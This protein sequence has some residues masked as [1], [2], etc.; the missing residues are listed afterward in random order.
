MTQNHIKVGW[1]AESKQPEGGIK[2]RSSSIII[3]LE[4]QFL[5]FSGEGTGTAPVK[6]SQE[7]NE[8]I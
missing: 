4:T 8:A 5:Q 3:P 6:S 1:P 7:P 2:N